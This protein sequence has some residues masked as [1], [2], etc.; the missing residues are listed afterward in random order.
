MLEDQDLKS[1]QEVR[2]KIALVHEAFLK[3]RTY[4]QD[5]VDRIVDRVAAV[6]RS[7]AEH[8]AK[9]AVEETGY[10]NVKDKTAKNLLNSDIL[11]RAIRPL[12]TVGIIREDRERGIIEIA[13]DTSRDTLITPDGR[14]Y[15][16]LE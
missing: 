11:H 2:T 14:V 8:L 13:D 10:G 5:Q 9:L 1:V 16:N 12:K 3:Y 4:T 6:A 7:H 15:A